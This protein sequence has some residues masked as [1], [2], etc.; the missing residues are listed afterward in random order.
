M[1]VISDFSVSARQPIVSLGQVGLQYKRPLIMADRFLPGPCFRIG[2][3]DLLMG[4]RVVLAKSETF[5][6]QFNRPPRI[7][8]LCLIVAKEVERQKVLRMPL[9]I[10]LGQFTN[11]VTLSAARFRRESKVIKR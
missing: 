9:Q 1:L 7:R 5:V 4:S 11:L 2:F 6:Q 10:S 8:P 3:G